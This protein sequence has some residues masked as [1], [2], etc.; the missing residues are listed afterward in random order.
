MTAPVRRSAHWSPALAL[1]PQAAGG[2]G[3]Q[4]TKGEGLRR[5]SFPSLL[6]ALLIMPPA[7]VAAQPAAVTEAVRACEA[8]PGAPIRVAGRVLCF[9]GDIDRGSAARAISLMAGR[10]LSAMVVTSDGGEVRAALALARALR[11]RGLTLV[12]SRRCI[13]SCAN[14]LFPA[15]RSKAVA[16]GGLVIFHGGIAPGALGGL[17]GDPSERELLTE[18]RAFFREI[19]VNGAITYDPPYRRDPRSGARVLAE[20]WSASPAALARHGIGGIVFLWWPS[21]DAVIRAGAAQ[22]IPLGILD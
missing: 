18:T 2:E 14:F 17:L 12:V 6:L 3:Q 15:A 9:A 7:S 8:A 20:Q 13:S 19:G 1:S 21:A 4:V 5:L 22:G 10:D 16:P 11:V